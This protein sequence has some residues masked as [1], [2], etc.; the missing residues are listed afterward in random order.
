MEELGLFNKDKAIQKSFGDSLISFDV[1]TQTSLKNC[2]K[3]HSTGNHAMRNPEQVLAQK[4]DILESIHSDKMPPKTSG[5]PAL[6]ACDK[7]I[8]ETWMDDQTQSRQSPLKVNELSACGN[9]EAPRA[10]PKTDFKTLPLSFDNFKNEIL[11]KKCYSCHTDEH[12]G[13]ETDLVDLQ[14]IKDRDMIGATAEDSLLYNVLIQ[15]RSKY[16][17][18]REGSGREPLTAEEI[19]YVKRWIDAG[20]N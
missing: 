5:Y 1:V 6:S 12:P 2:L 11:A 3:C 8:L 7:M 18:P 13:Y 17:M 14:D 4:K 19:D 9:I 20:A 15:G 10:E 16:F